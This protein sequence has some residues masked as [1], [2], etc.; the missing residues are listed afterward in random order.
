MGRPSGCNV[1][2][3]EEFLIYL[4]TANEKAWSLNELLT[5]IQ[6]KFPK[7]SYATVSMRLSF[8]RKSLKETIEGLKQ[9]KDRKKDIQRMEIVLSWTKL[10]RSPSM[11]TIIQGM[12]PDSDLE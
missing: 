12:I 7:Y 1:M 10:R 11:L 4:C 5:E 2:K 6:K 8:L 9:M 3:S